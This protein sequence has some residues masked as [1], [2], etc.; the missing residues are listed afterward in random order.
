VLFATAG[1]VGPVVPAL[2]ETT[3][4]A[5]GYTEPPDRTAPTVN[6]ARSAATGESETEVGADSETWASPA[7]VEVACVVGP[8]RARRLYVPAGR[9]SAKEPPDAQ[10]TTSSPVDE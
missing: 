3:A 6:S 2:T 5:A 9:E 1:I 8:S 4:P 10:V 7:E